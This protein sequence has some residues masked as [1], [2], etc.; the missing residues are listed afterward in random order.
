MGVCNPRWWLYSASAYTSKCD[1]RAEL[2]G[3]GDNT[4]KPAVV[5]I[6]A[7]L[8]DWNSNRYPLSSSKI[9]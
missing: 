9:Y 3:K 2:K 6:N 4:W 7:L 8:A 5:I 1:Y